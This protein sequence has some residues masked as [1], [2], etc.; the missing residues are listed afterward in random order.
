MR[1][2]GRN[3]NRLRVGR[4]LASLMWG[5]ATAMM[6][7]ARLE[8]EDEEDEERERLIEVGARFE[9][10]VQQTATRQ[11]SAIS[12]HIRVDGPLVG[13]PSDHC[14]G[15]CLD[16]CTSDDMSVCPSPNSPSEQQ[17]RLFGVPVVMTSG[18]HVFLPSSRAAKSSPPPTA[19]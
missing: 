9:H 16:P 17:A 10:A 13:V 11:Q 18:G 8:R 5:L 15:C 4:V 3:E 14:L 1:R 7:A 19:H 6:R 2:R 12:K